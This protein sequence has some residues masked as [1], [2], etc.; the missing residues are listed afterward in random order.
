MAKALG[1]T[2]EPANP[3]S[4]LAQPQEEKHRPTCLPFTASTLGGMR[5]G[6]LRT[7]PGEN[8]NHVAL[9]Q[10]HLAIPQSPQQPW[11]QALRSTDPII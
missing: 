4:A 5:S 6:E 10:N 11:L 8:E 7:H 3:S 9:P 1:R 2:P